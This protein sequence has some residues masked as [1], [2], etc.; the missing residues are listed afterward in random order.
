[1]ISYRASYQRDP[2]KSCNVFN[3]LTMKSCIITSPIV[4]WSYRW[5]IQYVRGLLKG[6]EYQEARIMG[7]IPETGYY[8]FSW[9]LSFIGGG[10]GETRLILYVSFTLTLLY[11]HYCV[12]SPHIKQFCNTSWMSYNLTQFSYCLPGDGA[13]CHTLTAQSPLPPSPPNP[14]FRC[15]FQV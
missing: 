2:S 4:C 8:N 3:V 12:C 1:M 15:R 5:L 9:I 13:T 11:L 14:C 6:R 10:G 7:T